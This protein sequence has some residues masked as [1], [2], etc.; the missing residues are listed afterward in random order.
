MYDEDQDP[1][2]FSPDARKDYEQ[3]GSNLLIEPD[4]A[5]TIN[6]KKFVGVGWPELC[7]IKE[8]SF[9]E[10][11]VNTPEVAGD[12]TFLV[13]LALEIAP[14]S[15]VA[16][17]EP[18][19]NAG[20]RVYARLRYNLGAYKR[21]KQNGTGFQN[22]QAAMTQMSNAMMKDLLTSLG[23]DIELGLTPRVLVNEY[24]EQI[25]GQ[26][27]YTKIRQGLGK[28][29]DKKSIEVTGFIPQDV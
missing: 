19:E 18:T 14:E 7:Q 23:M 15:E 8:I 22:G 10:P 6:G 2:A 21:A 27:V 26:K 28:G 16:E 29:Q 4:S 25:I 3:A 17:G 13:Q 11:G 9:E 1:Y 20:R 5:R 12:V 24:R